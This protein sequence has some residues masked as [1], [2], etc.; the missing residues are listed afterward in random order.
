MKASTH[1][2]NGHQPKKGNP[3]TLKK[4][5]NI[6]WNSAIFFQLGLIIAL[7]ASVFAMDLKISEK[8]HDVLDEYVLDLNNDFFDT[9]TLEEPPKIEVKKPIA[10]KE[11]TPEPVA[12]LINKITKVE[13]NTKE[14]ETKVADP[15]IVKIPDT[16]V[17]RKPVS[18]A[19]PIEKGP[20]NINSVEF[21]P[22]FPGCES[23]SNNAE[24]KQCLSD[25]ISALISRK[26]N[27]DV[28]ND[29]TS[30]VQRIYVEFRIDKNGVVTDVVAQAKDKGLQ[31]EAQRIVN[32]LPTMRPGMQGD[33][34]VDVLYML[35]I[36]FKMQ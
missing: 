12:K 13:N 1:K 35:P 7:L 8:K 21:A 4:K 22:V 6:R 15:T 16:P 27:T 25:K 24:R 32:K 3:I 19:K 28:A 20:K 14:P 36:V 17:I 31:K 33:T 2:V 34:K 10:K 18:P 11:P 29:D 23:L 9:Y 26:F 5:T 30:G